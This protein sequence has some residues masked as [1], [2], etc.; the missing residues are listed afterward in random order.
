MALTKRI[1]IILGGIILLLVLLNYGISRYI[2]KNLPE[3]IN[4]EKEVPYN[5][6][7]DD[8]DINLLSGSLTMH[9]VY[10]APKDSIED[11]MKL[12][13][14]ANIKAVKVS[15]ANLWALLKH[16]K[17]KVRRLLL[18]TPQVILYEQNNN[19]VKDEL[20]KPFKQTITTGSIGV[21]NGNFK[22]LDEKENAVLKASKIMLEIDNIKIDSSTVDESIPVKYSEYQFACD[23]FF[24]RMDR[25]YN[26]TASKIKNSESNLTINN[27]KLIP[28]YSRSAFTKAADKEKDLFN[29]AVKQVNVPSAD[30]G[31]INNELY[32]HTPQVILQ[33]VNAGVYRNKMV[34]DDPSIKKMYSEMLRSLDFDLKADKV[35]MKNSRILYEEQLDFTKP[36]AKVLFTDFYATIHNLYSPVNKKKFPQTTI[37]VQ[38]MFMGATPLKTV[39]SFNIMNKNDAFTFKG[40]MGAIKT[41]VT[42]AIL[43][44]LMNISTTGT[45]KSVMFNYSGNKHNATGTFAI[46]YDDL[47]VKVYEEDG[48]EKKGLMTALGNLVVKNDTDGDLKHKGIEVTRAKDKSFFNF[49]WL[50]TQDGLRKAMLPKI[51]EKALPDVR[52]AKP[53]KKDD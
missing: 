36:P 1:L 41:E 3:I 29:V 26:V 52:P 8:L 45:I 48:K 14:T 15:N 42:N 18:D 16:D 5:I 23:S 37:D 21:I 31:F 17:I 25:Y 19:S 33:N 49:L 46:N 11:K 9:N 44:P 24:Y 39:W 20:T 30:W 43:K 38:C 40:N 2:E 28:K 13:L 51:V 32:V 47:K 10:I 27:L 50:C 53:K 35:L 12:G 7:Y 34:K 22:L 4:A 6:T